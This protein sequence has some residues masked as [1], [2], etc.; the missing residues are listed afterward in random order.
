MMNA[1]GKNLDAAGRA[2]LLEDLQS[3]CTEEVAVFHAISHLVSQ[4]GRSFVIMDTPPTGHSMLLMDTAG[5]YHRQMLQ[6]MQ[7][8]AGARI[9]TP[10]MRIQDARYTQV[11]IVTLPE[12][13]PVSQAAAL[14]DDL[15]RAKVEP[16]AWI[17][18]RS[19]AAAGSAD[20]V[21]RAR[22]GGELRQMARIR[23]GLA[24]RLYVIP[25]KTHPLVGVQALE[26]VAL[27]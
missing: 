24:K 20:P 7:Q 25:L 15:R 9:I 17:V 26:Q 13:T 3:P 22:M 4:A 19:L 10:L 11:I 8:V 16:Y 27:P 5:A 18:N 1:R 23:A 14:Q 21:L 2:L 6:G 12:T